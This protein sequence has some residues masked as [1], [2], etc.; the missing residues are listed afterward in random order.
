VE[1]SHDT[2]GIV[3]QGQHRP[4]RE[5]ETIESQV[6]DLRCRARDR[7]YDVVAEYLDDG[8][9]GASLERPGLDRLRDALGCGEFDLVL[10]HPPD[11]LARK[12]V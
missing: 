1:R 4:S 3:R 2:D 6:E 12:V 10:F 7:G 5:G 11:R 9:S 8:Y